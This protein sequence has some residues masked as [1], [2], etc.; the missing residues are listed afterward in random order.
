M[1]SRSSCAQLLVAVTSIT[2]LILTSASF[3]DSRSERRRSIQEMDPA[4]QAELRNKWD[5]F[6]A[7]SLQR[8][9]DL[10][11][12]YSEL[13]RKP[14]RAQLMVTLRQYHQWLTELG[15]ATAS[16]LQTLDPKARV[17]RIRQ[18]QNDQEKRLAQVPAPED[19]RVLI[20]EIA[21]IVKEHREEIL[22][23]LQNHRGRRRFSP[24]GSLPRLDEPFI[25]MLLRDPQVSPLRQWLGPDEVKIL[26][27]KLSDKAQK[28]WANTKKS[29]QMPLLIRW[30][31]FSFYYG[32][33][34]RDRKPST[35]SEK[36]LEDYFAKDL[37]APVR[38]ELLNMPLNRM[39]A[40]LRKSYERA[41]GPEFQRGPGF[42]GRKRRRPHPPGEPP[43]GP[44]GR[45][46]PPGARGDRPPRPPRDG[47]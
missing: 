42:D 29:K 19:R 37:D 2:A 22:R 47:F 8:R 25:R 26:I 21:S 16:E 4:A 32:P 36:E 45:R 31:R 46:P 13:D 43:R 7:L 39:Q 38:E 33:E 24:R 20:N 3:A 18:I 9:D 12:L 6:Q 14:N 11:R 34:E 17:K 23:R 28:I 27:G 30:I 41:Q 1:M 44:R 40:E 10:R 35:V 5:R 15:S